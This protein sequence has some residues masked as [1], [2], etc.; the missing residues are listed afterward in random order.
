MTTGALMFGN[1][2]QHMFVDPEK[3]EENTHLT[4]NCIGKGSLNDRVFN[5]G[6][7]ILHHENGKTHWTK[8]AA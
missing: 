6:Y 8:L 4:Y 3:F 5:D 2:S 7:H 1:W